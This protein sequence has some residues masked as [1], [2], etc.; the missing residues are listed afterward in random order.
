MTEAK[1]KGVTKD[2]DGVA[3]VNKVIDSTTHTIVNPQ[4][5]PEARKNAAEATYGSS[6][7]NCSSQF[8]PDE[9][10]WYSNSR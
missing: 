3:A 1:S 7:F 10:R 9:A 5:P 4:A 2:A 8:F 6:R